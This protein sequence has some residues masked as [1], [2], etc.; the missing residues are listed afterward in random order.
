M[1]QYVNVNENYRKNLH[2]EVSTS[3]NLRG[4]VDIIVKNKS[5]GKVEEQ[6][7][8]NLIVYGGREWLIKKIFGSQLGVDAQVLNSEICWFGVGN[9]GGEPGNPLQCGCT[10]GSDKDLYNPVKMRYDNDS[11]N[12]TL[13]TYYGSRVMP[14]G[15]IEYGYY[16]RITNISIKEDHANPYKENGVI[17]YPNIIVEARLEVSNDDCCGQS[18]LEKD[19]TKSYADINEAA[20]FIADRTLTDPGRSAKVSS[21]EYEYY[22]YDP[23]R[24]RYYLPEKNVITEYNTELHDTTKS[25]IKWNSFSYSECQYFDIYQ[26]EEYIPNS[27]KGDGVIS[28]VVDPETQEEKKYALRKKLNHKPIFF[29]EFNIG[30]GG[31]PLLLRYY[32]SNTSDENMKKTLWISNDQNASIDGDIENYRKI[33]ILTDYTECGDLGAPNEFDNM[34]IVSHGTIVLSIAK[35]SSIETS[36]N[37]QVDKTI[38]T[39]V[40]FKTGYNTAPQEL[41]YSRN[42][43]PIVHDEEQDKDIYVTGKIDEGTFVCVDNKGN[44]GTYMF[45]PIKYK[46]KETSDDRDFEIK[47]DFTNDSIILVKQFIDLTTDFHITGVE[48]DSNSFGVKLYMSQEDIEKVQETQK[49]YVTNPTGMSNKNVITEMNP[50]TIISVYNPLDDKEVLADEVTPYIMIERSGMVTE[51]Y[52]PSEEHPERHPI[53]MKAY[54]EAVDTPY[55]MFNRVTFSTIRLNQNREVLIVWKLYF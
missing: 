54:T 8:H 16:K 21:T 13:N 51:S 23:R 47:S 44:Y 30:T 27:S 32:R 5:T 20:L 22:N 55:K 6:H 7:N 4:E 49:I 9:G 1:K 24:N 3:G 11:T 43:F 41:D 12:Q 25:T 18:Y 38:Y 2:D 45:Y 50:A 15:E 42:V 35:D 28:I 31:K 33:D 34:I 10:Y 29:G 39:S 19:Y 52:K 17:K 26:K 14:S 40:R 53:P 46:F 37:N 48:T 36:Q